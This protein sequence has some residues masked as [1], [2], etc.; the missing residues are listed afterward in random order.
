MSKRPAQDDLVNQNVIKRRRRSPVPPPRIGLQI[1][2][3]ILMN[4]QSYGSESATLDNQEYD[5]SRI[6]YRLTQLLK[7][8]GIDE[9]ADISKIEHLP[10]WLWSLE[11]IMNSSEIQLE[12]IYPLIEHLHKSCD[13]T[14]RIRTYKNH[15]SFDGNY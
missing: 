14:L 7:F 11:P 10:L 8:S 6:L 4:L 3:P 2:T 9:L 13:T 15:D 12:E 5:I 1:D